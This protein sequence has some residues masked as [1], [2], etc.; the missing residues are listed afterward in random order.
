M[1]RIVDDHALLCGIIALDST[2]ATLLGTDFY[3][4]LRSHASTNDF[5]WRVSVDHVLDTP[6]LFC[7]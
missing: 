3:S 7:L 1:A 5:N 6:L 4:L 2:G